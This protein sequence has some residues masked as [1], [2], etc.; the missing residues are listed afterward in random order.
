[1][2]RGRRSTDEFSR[3]AAEWLNVLLP[4]QNT[5][6]GLKTLQLARFGRLISDLPSDA[7]QRWPYTGQR[8]VPCRRHPESTTSAEIAALPLYRQILRRAERI[9]SLRKAQKSPAWAA[10]SSGRIC[11]AKSNLAML[12]I[13]DYT[14]P[15]IKGVLHAHA[16]FDIY[17]GHRRSYRLSVRNSRYGPDPTGD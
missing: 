9:L 17:G 14:S 7:Q 16:V 5:A 8:S 1:L 15:N 12:R 13:V 4:Q 2:C 11:S 10:C 6:D 3:I